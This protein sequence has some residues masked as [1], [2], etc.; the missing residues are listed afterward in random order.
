MEWTEHVDMKY[1]YILQCGWTL[2]D[3]T[4]MGEKTGTKDH[5]WNDSVYMK[6]PQ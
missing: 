4:K 1:S 2:K 3:D 6:C 5:I